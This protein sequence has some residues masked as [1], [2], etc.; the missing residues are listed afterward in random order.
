[1]DSSFP[2]QVMLCAVQQSAVTGR[3]YQVLG[4]SENSINLK[5]STCAKLLS[6]FF[7]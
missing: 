4:L 5:L 6:Q 2:W 7:V 3:T 1:M